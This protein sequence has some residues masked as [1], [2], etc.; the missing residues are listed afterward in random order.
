M[1]ISRFMLRVLAALLWALGPLAAH[2]AHPLIT[3]LIYLPRPNIDLDL[4]YNIERTDSL[5]ANV[6]LS[7]IV[8]RW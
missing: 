4:G 8:L 1:S 6:L 5:R 3:G 2:A 7:G